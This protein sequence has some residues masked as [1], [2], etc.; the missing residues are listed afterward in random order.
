MNG[1]AES[2]HTKAESNLVSR[3]DW[4][5]TIVLMVRRVEVRGFCV[6]NAKQN[7][8]N[9]CGLIYSGGYFTQLRGYSATFV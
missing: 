1:L 3:E 6:P 7:V 5:Y 8:E 9:W 2:W 4:L